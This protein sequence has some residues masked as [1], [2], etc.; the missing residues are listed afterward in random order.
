M[1]R[2]N[3]ASSER[4]VSRNAVVPEAGQFSNELDPDE[5]PAARAG[6]A[7][8]RPHPHRT[9]SGPQRLRGHMSED[10]NDVR[11]IPVTEA[12]ALLEAGRGVLVDVRDRSL[13]DNTHAAGAVSLP[14]A[15]IQA[16]QGQVPAGAVPPDRVLILYCA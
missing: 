5:V 9:F 3:M 10:T 7:L 8:D 14:L 11:R 1:E 15:V 16:T 2:V 13:Y 6:L 12:R 4:R